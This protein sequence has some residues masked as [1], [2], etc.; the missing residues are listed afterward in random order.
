MYSRYLQ[1]VI[2]ELL[3]TFRIV[4]LTGAR[5]AGKT[6][7]AQNLVQ[8]R[9]MAYFSLD[10]QAVRSAAESDPLGFIQSLHDRNAVL[11]EFQYLP[12]LIPAIKRISD[13]LPPGYSGKFLLTGSAD[14]FRSARTQES[15]P[16][17][18]ARLELYPLSI[19]EING[20]PRNLVSYLLAGEFRSE[21]PVTF[22][23][24]QIAAWILQGGY[25]EIQGK[26]TRARSLWFRSYVEGRLFKDFER[27]HAARGDYHTKLKAMVPYLAGLC[28][29]LL[30]YANVANDLELHNELT[31]TY[32]E[33]LELMF[34]IQ[35]VPAWLKNTAKREATKMPKLHFV[36]TGL[37]C[38]L[39]KLRSADQ[40]L[41][42][43]YYGGLFE[44]LVYLECA[45]QLGWA[46]EQCHLYHF[47]DRRKNE[48]DIVLEREDGSIIGLECKASASVNASDFRGLRALAAAAGKRLQ[49][50]VLIY[51]GEHVL[52]FK[53][54]DRK[55]FA[56]PIGL[57]F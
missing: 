1:P 40:L 35:R 15:L 26:S 16:G 54:D 10:D 18:M 31:K 12:E 32:I 6:T 43:Q 9:E 19:A 30:K 57:F 38:H 2:D 11:D 23:R 39:L 46:D 51:S 4:Y 34:I 14:I 48:V 52:P 13:G 5:Q 17:H 29:N 25:P 55:F 47:R 41:T 36:D 37:A 42:S 3:S 8:S 56:V 7:V 22:H 49:H 44:N 33:V 21:A 50:G 27:L 53:V 20:N 24:E 45:K 28:G